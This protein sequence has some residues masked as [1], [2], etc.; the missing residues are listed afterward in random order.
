[1]RAMTL[2]K[3][4]AIW[5]VSPGVFLVRLRLRVLAGCYFDLVSWLVV[6]LVQSE[7]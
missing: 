2:R 4:V 3:R 7:T 1:M 5:L 6:L